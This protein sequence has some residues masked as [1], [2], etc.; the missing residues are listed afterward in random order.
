M[1]TIFTFLLAALAVAGI[2][3]I[4]A[5]V[6]Q[7]VTIEG[8][9]NCPTISTH[10]GRAY[11][12]ITIGAPSISSSKRRAMNLSVVLDRSGSMGDQA[13]MEYARKALNSLIDQL[14]EGDIFSLV[15]Y[16]DVVEVLHRAQ[17]VG[18][19]ER[20][21]GLVERVSPRGSTNLGGGMVEGF[22]QV[23]RYAGKEFVN[24]VI[25][26][27]DGLANQGVT[28]PH[29]LNRIARRYR[30]KSISLT[31]MGVGADYNENLMVGLSESGGGSY[32]FIESPRTLASIMR[33][34]FN[35]LSTVV[36][37]NARIELR[38][39]RGVRLIDVIG[40]EHRSEGD[41]LEIPVGD[42]Y[43]GDRRELTVELDIPEGSGT[44]TAVRGSLRYEGTG[45][46]ESF[47]SFAA[48]VHYSND[49]AIIEKHRDREIQAKADVALS[50]RKVEQAMQAMDR[51]EMEEAAIELK[52]AEAMIAT[53]IVNAP[54]GAGAGVLLQQQSRLELYQNMLKDSV[55]DGRRAK[56]AIQYEN[57]RMLRNKQ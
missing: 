25:L 42:L 27:S 22:R 55:D 49:V 36:A 26:L 45:L 46:F 4:A 19:T 53:S 52:A 35:L 51:G 56:K 32:Y 11:L 37:Q 3:A 43:A 31:T 29:E 40:F 44:L 30:G 48:A 41:R 14:R 54:S 23:E 20:L 21:K 7:G 15:I 6:H 38:P 12:H 16:D 10:G 17:R 18:N 39:G 5:G 2:P 1:K 33:K 47:P 9:L 8:K 13:K 28:D 57:Y 50:T 24:R 34:E